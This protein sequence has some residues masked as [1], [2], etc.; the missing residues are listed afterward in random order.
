M[1]PTSPIGKNKQSGF[2]L[3]E[4]LAVLFIIAMMAGAVVMSLPPKQDPLYEQGK[5]LATRIGLA[6]Q[7][8]LIEQQAMGVSF[9]KKGYTILKYTDQAWEIIEEFEFEG[10][11]A[12]DLELR[13]NEAPVD[14]EQAEK[15]EIPVIRYDTTGLGTAFELYLTSGSSGF[16]ITGAIDGTITAEPAT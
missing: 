7:T 16:V 2:T 4:V 9:T 1:M 6:A 5:T 8:G 11:R 15:S 10:D 13:E 14:L 3:I 12:P